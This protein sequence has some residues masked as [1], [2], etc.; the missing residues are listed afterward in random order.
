MTLG[1]QGCTRLAEP[2]LE[3]AG[4]AGVEVVVHRTAHGVT[5]FASS[6]IH[7][8]TFADDVLVNV[9]VVT[10]DGR[11]GV[12]GAHTDAPAEVAALAGRALA[13]ARASPA[14]EH[15]PG[16]APPAAAPAVAVD[17]AVMAATPDL[18]AS[19]V[20][21]VLSRIA[22]A[23]EGPGTFEAAGA[24]TT[25]GAELAVLTT[26]GQVVHTPLSG[27]HLNLVVTGPASS[28][29]AESGGRALVDVDPEAVAAAAVAKASADEPAAVDAG[30]W[31]VVLEPAATGTLVQFLARL[32]FGAKAYLEGRAFTAQRM[33][34]AATDPAVSMVD[35]A[36]SPAAVGLP[37]DFEGTVKQPV[38]L[39]RDG[40]V[41]GVVH[42]RH[43]AARAGV[44]STGH[45]LLAPNPH[46][47]VAMNPLIEPGDAG[48]VADLVGAVERG[49]LVTRLHYT[50]V[51][52]PMTTVVTGMTRDGTFLVEGGRITRAV[53]NL[54][55]TQS[56]LEALAQVDAVSSETGYASEL[57]FGGGRYPALRLPAF[58]FTATTC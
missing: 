16:L 34:A 41:A 1:L 15:F 13:I 11:V 52:E 43:T 53:R 50:N 35:D 26:R 19:A 49:L 56:I 9:R 22:G 48:S 25:V 45:G 5:R 28:G 46:G 54:R 39:L 17:E 14:D 36:L 18:R 7:Q 3:L 37:F 30:S 38:D 42:D 29:Y 44:L 58:R 4:A 51:V 57:F 32:G 2:A 31:P 40:V 27:A 24:Y 8:N 33:G 55:F 21:R 6:Q 20:R 23:A 47:P 12:A 10:A